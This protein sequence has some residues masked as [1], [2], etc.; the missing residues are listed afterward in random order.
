MNWL[1]DLG[2]TRLK[3]ARLGVQG[4]Q[5]RGALAHQGGGFDAALDAAL[6]AMPRAR[7][8][9]LASVA[10]PDLGARVRALCARHGVPCLDVQTREELAGVRVAYAEPS[11]LGVDR[12]LALLAAHARGAGPWLLVSVGT[13]LTV[14]ALAAD[15]VHLGGVIAPSPA[16]MREALA[17]RVPQLRN[18]GGEPQTFARTTRDALAGGAQGAALGLIE[19]SYAQASAAFGCAPTLLLGGG[20]SADLAPALTLPHR[21]APDLV[22]E[23]LAVWAAQ[24]RISR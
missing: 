5:E 3:W 18:D 17:A 16:L 1:F 4:L 20:G 6:D 21:L 14:D 8:A 15:G 10:A 7:Q 9:W 24:A 23:G 19:R 2:N 11:Q 12:F 22:L 13:A